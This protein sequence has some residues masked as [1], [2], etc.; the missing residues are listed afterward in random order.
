MYDDIIRKSAYK[1]SKPTTARIAG[2][3]FKLPPDNR[4]ILAIKVQLHKYT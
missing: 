4:I 3:E 1:L 2:V